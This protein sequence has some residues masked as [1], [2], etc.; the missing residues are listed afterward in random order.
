M[1][2]ALLVCSN[3]EEFLPF[4][5]GLEENYSVQIGWATSGVDA[6]ATIEKSAPDLLIIGEVLDDMTGLGFA[7]KVAAQNPLINCAMASGVSSDDFHEATEGLG[8]LMQLSPVPT[9]EDAERLLK[10][11]E[12]IMDLSK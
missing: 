9:K 4:A 1:A 8:I 3:K 5:S 12:K 2:T 7:R 10:H 11:A 6:L